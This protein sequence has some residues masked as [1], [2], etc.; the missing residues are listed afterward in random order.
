[1]GILRWLLTFIVSVIVI[2]FSVSNLDLVSVKW[3]LF[4]DPYDIPL[5][6]IILTALT[7]GFFWGGVMVW[8]SGHK[9]RSKLRHSTKEIKRLEVDL[10]ESR[11]NPVSSTPVIETSL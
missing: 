8:F 9:T 7:L 10:E 2:V 5:Y 6:A 4:H 1:M 11:K 3:S